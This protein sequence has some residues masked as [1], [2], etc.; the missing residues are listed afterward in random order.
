MMKFTYVMLLLQ[1]EG[2]TTDPT[3]SSSKMINFEFPNGQTYV[4]SP[5]DDQDYVECP[6]QHVEGSHAMLRKK[7]G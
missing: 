2:T 6:L 1:D 3:P 4:P 5:S 7:K